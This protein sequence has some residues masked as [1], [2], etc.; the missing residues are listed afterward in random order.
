MADVRADSDHRRTAVPIP[1]DT[2][3]GFGLAVGPAPPPAPALARAA[4]PAAIPAPV[5][6]VTAESSAA[7]RR[8]AGG[9]ARSV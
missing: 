8:A 1:A 7:G 6:A 9:D 2:L 3:P 4:A 5:P